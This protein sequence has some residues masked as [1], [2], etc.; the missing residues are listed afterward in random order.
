MFPRG[1]VCPLDL[2][3]AAGC[4]VGIVWGPLAAA[5]PARALSQAQLRVP[6]HPALSVCR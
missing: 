6:L 1:P 3:L 5:Q 2:G 4:C